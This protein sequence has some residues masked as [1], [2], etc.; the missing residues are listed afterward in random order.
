MPIAEY[1]RGP[2]FIKGNVE[3]TS[4]VSGI[5]E[6]VGL[7]DLEAMSILQETFQAGEKLRLVPDE[8]GK[9]LRNGESVKEIT[10]SKG[11]SFVAVP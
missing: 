8:Q 11:V 1:S 3:I 9:V 7:H 4:V 10:L 2:L 6:M 5:N